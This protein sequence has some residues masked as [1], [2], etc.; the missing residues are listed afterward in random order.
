M[1]FHMLSKETWQW[2][3][4]VGQQ[5]HLDIMENQVTDFHSKIEYNYCILEIQ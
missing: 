5:M 3:P 4:E 1:K 2:K